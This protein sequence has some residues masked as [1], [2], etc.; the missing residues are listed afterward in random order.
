MTTVIKTGRINLP[1]NLIAQ[2]AP[3]QAPSII[4]MPIEMPKV[5]LTWP[6]YIKVN[7]LKKL[8]MKLV[9]RAK[10]ELNKISILYKTFE[11]LTQKAPVPGPAI[12]S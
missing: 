10:P 3:T 4:N 5:K 2:C 8:L 7:K 9:E 6:K 11:E 1:P 12:P